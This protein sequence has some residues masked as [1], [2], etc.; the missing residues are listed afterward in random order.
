M[1]DEP[2]ENTP[3]RRSDA[4][5]AVI[6]VPIRPAERR[7]LPKRTAAI[8]RRWARETF[9]REQLISSLKSLLW[10]APLTLLI[11]IYAEREQQKDQPA[12]FQVEVRSGTPGQVARLADQSGSQVAMVSAMLRGP[13]GRLGEVMESLRAGVP[14]QITID[15]GRQPG[16]HDVEILQLIARDPRLRD[17]AVS[18][19]Q[20]QPRTI[21]VEVDEVQEQTLDVTVDPD[22]R[23]RLNAAPLFDPPQVRVSAPASAFQKAKR[24]LYA[25]ATLPPDLLT[26]GRHGP[27][28][29]RVTVP[30]LTD[31]DVTLRQPNVMATVDVGESE[32]VYKIPSLPVYMTGTGDFSDAYHVSYSPKF[33]QQVPVYGSPER[34]QQLKAGQLPTK[35][36][37]HLVITPADA[38]TGKGTRP[39]EYVL[40]EGITMREEDKQQATWEVIRREGAQ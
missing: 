3:S 36:Y 21:R 29:A 17:N 33:A 19:T 23:R 40:P 11:W 14:V 39:L 22:V 6:V 38:V 1:V 27:A 15:G 30:G 16:L 32:E 35:P 34:I 8:L 28:S 12:Q 4:P 2:N 13:K 10:V 20:C 31:P 26:P 24:P 18:V 9:N 25:I 37:A 5:A 7:S